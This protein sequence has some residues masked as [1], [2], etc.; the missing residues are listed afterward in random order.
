M[1]IDGFGQLG[2]II[3]ETNLSF[4]LEGDD[5]IALSLLRNA[6][7]SKKKLFYL[8]IGC[9]HPHNGNNTNLF[10]N[11]GFNGICVDPLPGL[12][13]LYSK[14]RPRDLFFKGS[15]GIGSSN[16]LMNIYDDNTASSCDIETIKR[17][18]QKFNLVSRTE[19]EYTEI[20]KL[21]K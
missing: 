16:K 8:D 4:S 6:I 1:G 9:N 5:R 14:Y 18:D 12:L 15:V 20:D 19:I 21:I 7:D 2:K 11:M 17:Y 13:E 10:Y 3:D